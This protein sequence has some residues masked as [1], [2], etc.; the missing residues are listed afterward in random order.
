M[1][2]EVLAFAPEGDEMS[3]VKMQV[4]FLDIHFKAHF[5][6]LNHSSIEV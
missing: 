1:P 2:V 6:T 5:Y 3:C 4:T